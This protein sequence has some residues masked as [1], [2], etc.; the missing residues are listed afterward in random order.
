MEFM[1][2][3]DGIIVWLK[4]V[5]NFVGLANDLYVANVYIVPETSVYLCHDAFDILQDDLGGFPHNSDILVCGD[6]N[7]H[8][9]VVPDFIGEFSNGNNEDLHVIIT[10]RDSRSILIKEMYEKG[11]SMR[12]SPYKQ[13]SH[14]VDW[15]MWSGRFIDSKWESG[16]RQKHRGLHP[17]W[18]HG[19]EH[20]RSYDLQPWITVN[21]IWIYDWAQIS[22]FW[23]LWMVNNDT[24]QVP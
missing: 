2:Y 1:K 8:T 12:R 4:L 11:K 23:P 5:K 18:H 24:V 15:I 9:N 17:R 7:A 22:R 13:T 20:S 14:S 16:K 3:T 21:N 6:Y 10:D 19:P